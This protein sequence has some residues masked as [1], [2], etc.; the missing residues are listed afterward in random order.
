[1]SRDNL[2]ARLIAASVCL[3]LFSSADAFSGS[4]K[5][6]S[7]HIE[8]RGRSSTPRPVIASTSLAHLSALH[9]GIDILPAPD[10]KG[11]GAFAT[12]LISK[13]DVLGEYTGEMLTRKQVEARYWGARKENKHD[14]KWRNSRK[15][16]DQGMTGDY[17]FDMGN[18]LFIDGEDADVSSW[19]RF[20][21]HADPNV[22]AKCNV[23]VRASTDAISEGTD[24]DT[25]SQRANRHLFFYAIMDIDKS[26][27]LCYDYGE[28]YWGGDGI[29]LLI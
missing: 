22:G 1:M 16:R 14:R 19:C 26:T 10:G 5:K 3:H 27:E 9:D 12:A 25:S 29:S 24:T 11:M 8:K 20:A 4:G 21:N 6:R 17:I 28:E 15:R 23:E 13:G 18:D 7:A 2:H